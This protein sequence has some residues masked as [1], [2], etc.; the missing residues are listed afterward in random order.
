MLPI[1]ALDID[2]WQFFE[3]RPTFVCDIVGIWPTIRALRFCTIQ[4]NGPLPE[5]PSI[6]LRELRLPHIQ[7]ATVLERLLPPPPPNQQSNLLF[8]ELADITEEARAVLSV[9]GHSVSTLALLTQPSF[10]IAQLFP[11]LEELVIMDPFW[12]SPFPA[13]PRTLKHIRLAHG[14]PPTGI[15]AAIAHDTPHAMRS[16]DGDSSRT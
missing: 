12:R 13:F 7:P 14:H 11:R 1:E 4:N 5:R 2:L 6:I 15:T 10:E 16:I 8:L 3:L 9:H